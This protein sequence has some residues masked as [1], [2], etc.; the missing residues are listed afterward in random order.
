MEEDGHLALLLNS[1]IS[2][3][4]R[5]SGGEL[6]ERVHSQGPGRPC[7]GLPEKEVRGPSERLGDWEG[8]EEMQRAGGAWACA[9]W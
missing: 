3:F 2:R 7:W 6:Q 5:A 1:L 8:K 9:P 4:L